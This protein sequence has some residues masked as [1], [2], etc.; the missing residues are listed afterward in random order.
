MNLPNVIRR[1]VTLLAVSFGLLSAASAANIAWIAPTDAMNSNANWSAVNGTYTQNFGIAFTTGANAPGKIDWLTLGLNT[2]GVTSGSASLTVALRNTTNSTP[3]SAVAGTTE[4]AA[5]V[6]SFS[7]PTTTSTAFN[8]NL[9][10]SDLPNLTRYAL[11]ANTAYALVLYAPSANIGLMRKTGYLN[12]TT[13]GAYDV[14]NGFTMLDTFRNNSANYTNNTNSYPALSIAFGE[15]VSS[16]VPE[17]AS[18][19]SALLLAAAGMMLCH[20]RKR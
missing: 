15:T 6:I 3:Y 7:M 10:A 1:L 17:T 16:A 4:H 20:R 19:A 12:G 18:T 2:S 13:N 11:Q 5:D 8:L 14:S 9:T